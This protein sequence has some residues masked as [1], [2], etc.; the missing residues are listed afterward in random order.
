M[1]PS[2]QRQRVIVYYVYWY[3]KSFAHF[4]NQSL[5]QGH[6]LN[7]IIPFFVH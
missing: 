2:K 3:C 4:V 1:D 7:L 6:V 5:G